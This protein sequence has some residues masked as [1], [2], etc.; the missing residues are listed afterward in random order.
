MALTFKV[1]EGFRI[2][3]DQAWTAGNTAVCCVDVEWVEVAA[4]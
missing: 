2:R 1:G 4:Y 3:T